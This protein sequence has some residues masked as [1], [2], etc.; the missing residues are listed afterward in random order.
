[1]IHIPLVSVIIP[2]YNQSHYLAAAVQ[3]VID[4]TYPDLEIIIVDDGST[5]NT[6]QVTRQFSDSRIRYIRQANRGLAAARNTGINAA[7]GELLSFLDSD[8]LFLPEKIEVLLREFEFDSDL[9]FVAGQAQLIDQNGFRLDHPFFTRLNP[10]PA[11]LLLGNPFHVGSVLLQRSWQIKVG[12]FEESLRSYEDWD[13]WLRLVLAGCRMKVIDQPVSLYRFHTAQMTRNGAQMTTATQAVLQRIYERTDLPANWLDLKPEAY[14]NAYLRAA[15]QAYL[16]EEYLAAHGFLRSV[17]S[18]KPSLSE[19]QARELHQRFSGWAELPKS[20]PPAQFL[21]KIYTHLP[22]E[23]KDLENRKGTVLGSAFLNQALNHYHAGEP[24]QARHALQKSWMYRPALFFNRGALSVF[25]HS[26]IGPLP[27]Q[28]PHAKEI[29]SMRA[30]YL[31][32]QVHPYVILFI[33]RDG[34]TYLTSLLSTHPQI[35]AIYER[36]AV[37][38][39]KGA[40]SDEQLA[41]A[42]EFFTPRWLNHV[43][44]VGFKTKLIDVFDLAGF[45]ALLKEKNVCI[46][47]MQRRNRVKAVVSRINARRLFESSGNWNLYKESDRLEAITIAPALFAKYLREREQADQELEDFTRTLNLNTLKIVYEDLLTNRDGT[48]SKIF[49]FLHIDSVA[50]AGKTIK[51][52]SDNLRDAVLNFDELRNVYAQTPYADQF[53]EVLAAV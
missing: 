26:T 48:L 19:N 3:S 31:R 36:F 39:Q 21:E 33:E 29:P 47:Q 45:G 7:Q 38:K 40:G 30:L 12:L 50:L 42:R 17:L 1:M 16:N 22:E 41:W 4:Q 49:D 28:N 6:P 8:D 32:P 24:S 11:E 10:E 51:N 44:A 15:A 20:I 37:L 27:L 35:D 43:K 34:S 52:T 18:L 53:D 13:Y 25:V 2:A 5:D 46:I 9:G 14:A 23:L